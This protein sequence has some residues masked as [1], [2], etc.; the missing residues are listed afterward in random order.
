VLEDVEDEHW[1]WDTEVLV[2]AQRAGYS[3]K[4]FPVGWEPKGDTTV[5]PI[6]DVLGMGS[7]IA[8]LWWQLSVEPRIDRRTTTAAGTALIVLAIALMTLYLDPSEVLS[9][10]GGADPVVVALA[11]G[12]YLLSWP[13]RGLRYRD[14]LSELGYRE[15]SAF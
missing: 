12:I 3:I 15:R 2:R 1:F 10:I 9:A 7:G 5:D 4:E 11:A 6:R 13:L 8:R 14:I